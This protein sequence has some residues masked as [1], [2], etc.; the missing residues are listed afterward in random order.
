MPVPR[1]PDALDDYRWDQLQLM[2]G[3][4][5]ENVVLHNC[6]GLSNSIPLQRDPV[7]RARML[8]LLRNLQNLLVK[9][10][11]G[12]PE[13]RIEAAEQVRWWLNDDCA[14]EFFEEAETEI[15]KKEKKNGLMIQTIP[16][17]EM[18]MT[19]KVAQIA[20]T[21]ATMTTMMMTIVVVAL[22]ATAAL[23]EVDLTMRESRSRGGLHQALCLQEALVR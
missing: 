14:M 19:Q 11:S 18:E 8:R 23:V 9:F 2:Q 22:V 20:K 12:N 6:R 3:I 17:L 5:P 10:Q 4:G 16:N 15:Q 7:E 1:A 13:K 21:V